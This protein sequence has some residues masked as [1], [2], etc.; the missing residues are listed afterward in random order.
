MATNAMLAERQEL[1]GL[2][3]EARKKLAAI[4][5]AKQNHQ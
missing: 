3:Q 4:R 5:A 2:V 1:A